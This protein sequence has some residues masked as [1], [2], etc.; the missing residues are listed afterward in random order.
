M[1]EFEN[2]HDGGYDVPSDIYG[3]QVK[4]MLNLYKGVHRNKH[5][6][7][8]PKE[9]EQNLSGNNLCGSRN[10]N[11]TP[12]PPN[13]GHTTPQ[14]SGHS[15]P[16]PDMAN[17]WKYYRDIPKFTG[18]PGEMGATHLIKLGDMFKISEI[19]VP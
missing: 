19:E 15:T 7:E 2:L 14:G 10:S 13:S 5:R 9:P 4:P 18:A 6:I 1:E 17:R 8:I 11:P 3:F 16:D 12:T